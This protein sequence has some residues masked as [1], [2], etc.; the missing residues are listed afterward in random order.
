MQLSR[1]T[2]LC[3]SINYR[4]TFS[5]ISRAYN[6][7]IRCKNVAVASSTSKWE[8]KSG[9]E[10]MFLNFYAIPLKRYVF[11]TV[12][13][14]FLHNSLSR[15]LNSLVQFK[16]VFQFFSSTKIFYV[17][18]ISFAYR[19]SNFVFAGGNV[20]SITRYIYVFN[21]IGTMHTSPV[22]ISRQR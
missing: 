3:R 10:I 19:H 16:Q 17:N 14:W 2:R 1:C 6:E 20:C 21:W 15:A 8:S 9:R 22:F 18:W 13:I 7:Y 5:S 12:E 11:S 4:V